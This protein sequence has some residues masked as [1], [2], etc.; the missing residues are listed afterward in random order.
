ML[1]VPTTNK[2]RDS[3]QWPEEIKQLHKFKRD[4]IALC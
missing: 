3:I 2:D 1:Y 4:S